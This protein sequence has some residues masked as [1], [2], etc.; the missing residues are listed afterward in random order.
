[1]RKA[2]VD[3]ALHC[4]RPLPDSPSCA[5]ATKP[6]MLLAILLAI[7]VAGC[8]QDTAQHEHAAEPDR[9]ATPAHRRTYAR[10]CNLDR[11][12]LTPQ[13]APDCAFARADL[14]T[15]DPDEL[16]RLTLDFERQ[17]YQVA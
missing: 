16:A 5:P 13:P 11:S 2:I 4:M 14:K 9:L 12:L 3:R 8:A 15:V 10:I 6:L 7:A 17:C 1:M